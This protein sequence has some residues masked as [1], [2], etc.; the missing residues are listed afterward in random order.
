MAHQQWDWS[1]REEMPRHTTKKAL[2]K[3]TVGI[4][5][6]HDQRCL[7]L[8]CGG[9]Q[10]CTG[11]VLVLRADHRVRSNAVPGKISRQI[12]GIDILN[13]ILGRGKD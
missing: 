1:V 13:V 3:T 12:R 11:G 6:H 9:N 10:G 7:L 8:A 2:S 5:A 4:S